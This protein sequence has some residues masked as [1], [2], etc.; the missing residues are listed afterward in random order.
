MAVL[1]RVTI[2][3]CPNS[4]IGSS[5]VAVTAFGITTA[6][7]YALSGF[8]DWRL[9]AFFIGGG[10]A[11]G[12]LGSRLAGLLATR[13]ALLVQIFAGVVAVVGVYVVVRGAGALFS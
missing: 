1:S 3:L 11:G 12:L 13:K 8:V 2:T 10:I 7:S 6:A 4:A 5:L 9:V